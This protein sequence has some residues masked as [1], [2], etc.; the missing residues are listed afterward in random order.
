MKSKIKLNLAEILVIKD[1]FD[2][3]CYTDEHKERQLPFNIK[4]K[5]SKILLFLERDV[6]YFQDK[7]NLLVYKYG[8]LSDDKR[9]Y[10]VVNNEEYTKELQSLLNEEKEHLLPLFEEDDLSQIKDIIDVNYNSI[11]II[12]SYLLNDTEYLNSLNIKIEG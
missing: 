5:I 2:K 8:K 7:K 6:K 12:I 4:Y 10:E 1:C 11:K 9:Y 3:L